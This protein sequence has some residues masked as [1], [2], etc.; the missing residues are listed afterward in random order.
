MDPAEKFGYSFGPLWEDGHRY[1]WPQHW[2]YGYV[3]AE[4]NNF[5]LYLL[6]S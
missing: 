2:Y 6:S 5:S 3:V 4:D 1:G